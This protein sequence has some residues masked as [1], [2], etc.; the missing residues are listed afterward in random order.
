M[1]P[2]LGKIADN[3]QPGPLASRLRH[4]RFALFRSLLAR[5]DHPLTIL[6]VGGT[7]AFWEQMGAADEPEFRVVLVNLGAT[8][9]VRGHFASVVGDA[10]DLAGIADH[11]FDVVFSNSVIEHLGDLPA[12]RRMAS[13]VGRVGRRYFVQTPNRY[14]PIDPHDAVARLARSSPKWRCSCRFIF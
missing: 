14:F 7:E 3:M 12:Q 2:W 11:E 4:K 8:P 13:E 9:V 10:A 1:R 5:V 6:D